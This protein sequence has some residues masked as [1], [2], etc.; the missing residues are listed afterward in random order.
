VNVL[1]SAG[2]FYLG[3]VWKY[4]HHW[5][6]NDTELDSW[7]KTVNEGLEMLDLVFVWHLLVTKYVTES[8]KTSF[9]CFL[10]SYC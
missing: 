9:H 5:Q 1:N 10:K 6:R 7:T 2:G 8:Q 3:V 4:H